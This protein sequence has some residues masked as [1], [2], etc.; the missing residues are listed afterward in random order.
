[1]NTKLSEI[2]NTVE[3]TINKIDQK[4]KNSKLKDRLSE[5]RKETMKWTRSF[6]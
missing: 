5:N 4:R 3:D 6:Q 1:M 2:N